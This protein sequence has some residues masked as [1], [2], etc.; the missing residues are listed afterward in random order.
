MASSVSDLKQEQIKILKKYKD[1]LNDH[2]ASSG[3]IS[4]L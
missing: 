2:D 1:L 4:K 3:L